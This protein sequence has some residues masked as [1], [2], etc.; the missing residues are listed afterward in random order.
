MVFQF[1]VTMNLRKG[2]FRRSL[3]VY[4]IVSLLYHLPHA[5]A[6]SQ[7][8]QIAII[9]N[10]NGPLIHILE[11]DIRD[12]YL[13]EIR[14]VRGVR[15]L[16]IHYP[17]GRVKDI[18]LSRMLGQSSKAYRLHW[19]RKVFQEGLTLPVVK[20]NPRE[21]VELVESRPGAIGYVPR[22]WVNGHE[23]IRI[24]SSFEITNP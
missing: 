10:A 20:S 23:G 12:I 16:P 18:F 1:L 11:S 2:I 5:Y 6:L 9:V 22:R 8:E 15:A 3:W 13:G 19:A 14:F 24:I 17:E 21:I 7:T 4:A